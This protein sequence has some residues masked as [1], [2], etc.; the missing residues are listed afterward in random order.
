MKQCT[1]CLLDVEEETII[2]C[3][4]VFHL[5]CI[6]Q[7]VEVNN[8]CPT[9]RGPVTQLVRNGKKLRSVEAPKKSYAL[10]M[11]GVQFGTPR[12]PRMPWSRQPDLPNFVVEGVLREVDRSFSDSEESE[13]SFVE[14]KTRDAS[15][16]SSRTRSKKQ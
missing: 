1:I 7:W 14:I 2:D 8:V 5:K 4:H 10:R 6:S 3:S 12:R 11:D 13:I 16:I 9:C 15:P